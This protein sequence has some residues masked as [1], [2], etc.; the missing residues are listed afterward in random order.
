MVSTGYLVA[1]TPIRLRFLGRLKTIVVDDFVFN[2]HYRVTTVLFLCFSVLTTCN[3]FFGNPIE[4]IKGGD[5]PY[6]VVNTFCWIEGTFTIPRGLTK[7]V[8]TEVAYPGITKYEKFLDDDVVI[9]HKYYQV[10]FKK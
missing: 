1:M 6:N 4:C 5:V 8:G 7:A 2:L 10:L 3:Q 9:E